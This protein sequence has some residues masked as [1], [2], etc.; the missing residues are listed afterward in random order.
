MKCKTILL[1]GLLVFGQVMITANAALSVENQTKPLV[2]VSK[3]ERATIVRK[4]MGASDVKTEDV[5]VIAASDAYIPLSM[6]NFEGKPAGMLVDIWR[7]WA[8]K[9]GRRIEFRLSDW[10]ETLTALRNGDADIHSGLFRSKDRQ[11]WMD[12]SQPFYEVP[13][14]IYYHAEL[15]KLSGLE[16][17]A[18]FKVGAVKGSFQAQ[19]LRQNLPGA[20]VVTFPQSKAMIIAAMG[21]R[22][23]AFLDEAPS[24]FTL[25][26]QMGGRGL[27]KQ[28]GR[29]LFTKKI[30]ASVKKGNM[31]ILQL[32]DAGF[33]AVTRQELAEIENRWIAESELR[34]LN[35][36]AL[37]IR[38]TSAEETW[39]KKHKTIRLGVDPN[40]PP[41]DY[42]GED[43]SHMGMAADY[44]RLLNE[45]LG[46]SMKVVPSLIWSEVITGAKKRAIDVLPA[47]IKTKEKSAYLN[48]TIPYASFPS[49]IVTRTDY[50]FIGDLKD[51]YGKKVAVAKDYYTHDTLQDEHPNIEVFL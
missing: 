16:D 9:T 4:G 12:F 30:H 7:L 40:W 22:I 31:E 25:L 33:N 20:E 44:V 15:G 42:I 46:M 41:F 11:A 17:L 39:L 19:Y 35:K 45:R 38:L 21:K 23:Q 5:L 50:P 6:R 2:V 24:S 43:G 18:G 36:A 49:V 27:F 14:T 37:G 51:L 29:S 28:L 47:V 1:V 8:Q 26:D 3:E 34:Q 13:S 10:S 48:F 32:V